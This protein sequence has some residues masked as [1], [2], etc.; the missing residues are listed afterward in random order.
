MACRYEQEGSRTPLI[1]WRRIPTLALAALALI[2]AA[3]L[4]AI[5]PRLTG[6]S[7]H[8][9]TAVA[10]GGSATPSL[11][12]G[13]V[14]PSIHATV[15][16]GPLAVTLVVAPV[17]V[18]PVH[19]VA[20]VRDRGQPVTKA[21][22]RL[23]LSMP[24]QPVFGVALLETTRRADGFRAQGNLQAL[25][26]WR[27]NVLVRLGHPPHAPTDVPFDIMNG[28]N[29]RFLIAQPPNTHFGPATVRLARAADG[30]SVL[31]VRLRP[32]LAVRLVLDMPN[33]LSMGQAVYA[34][35]PLPRGWY[36]VSLAFPMTGVTQVTLQVRTQAGWLGAR[37]LLY[38]VDSAGHATLLTNTPT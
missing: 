35:S 1:R 29:A 18:G 33:M 4:I 36:G 3:V 34:A 5:V 6:A 20:T 14:P 15:H 10:P 38:D 12:D 19:F 32:R 7:S 27:V 16:R 23:Q 31:R 13:P 26:R 17:D 2:G 28:A 30:S 25:G 21:R 22:V 8:R 37:T 9:H 11:P 24:T